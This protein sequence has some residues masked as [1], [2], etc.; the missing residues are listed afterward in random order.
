MEIGSFAFAQ[1]LRVLPRAQITRAVGRL[2][3]LPLSPGVSRAVVGAY[4][5]AYRVD[6]SEAAPIN[7][8]GTYPSF[9]AFF[10]RELRDGAR[11][12]MG[13]E[14]TPVC[15]ADGRLDALGAIEDDGRFVVKG[16][17]YS[18]A[19]L[20][21]S[22]D[23]AR[24]YR[25]GNYALIYLSPRDY[26]RVHAPVGGKLREVRSQAGELFPVNSISERHIPNFLGRNRRVAI[27]IDSPDAGL[28]TVVMV[29]AMIVGRVTVTGID[30]RDVSYGT[31][32]LDPPVALARGDELGI[33]HLG[34]TAVVF[35][36]PGRPRWER[37]L[38][39]VR[40]GQPLVTTTSPDTK[41][42][43]GGSA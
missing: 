24:R 20:L 29:A 13:S 26:H 22:D 41:T 16:R 43:T 23:A 15:P 17:S 18:A 1:L 28:V 38:G 36:E 35:G 10:T 9:D 33:F 37:A 42:S 40:L 34:S 11:P 12:L 27:E 8:T 5:S 6:M 7:G 39:A 21:V 31:H 25:G 4:A 14:A 2:C 3:E 19:E 32:R 30:E